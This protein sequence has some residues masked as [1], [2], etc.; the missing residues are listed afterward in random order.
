VRA[1]TR[2]SVNNSFSEFERGLLHKMV[3]LT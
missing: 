3:S 1:W 2:F